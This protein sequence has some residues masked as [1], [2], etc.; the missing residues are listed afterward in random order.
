MEDEAVAL[1]D[2]ELAEPCTYDYTTIGDTRFCGDTRPDGVVPENGQIEWRTD[3]LINMAGW[4]IC[5]G[6]LPPA[7]PPSAPSPPLPPRAPP[8]QPPSP[9]PPF[10]PL[11]PLLPGQRVIAT[12][13]ELR[14]LF[15]AASNVSAASTRSSDALPP[16]AVQLAPGIRYSLGGLPLVC[17]G[18]MALELRGSFVGI[19]HQLHLSGYAQLLRRGRAHLN[20]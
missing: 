6:I 15:A 13:E 4:E 18:S 11:P 3:S 14:D 16:T 8:L 10:P 12:V 7:P 17:D 9:P 19:H 20:R 2:Y 5:F 1:S